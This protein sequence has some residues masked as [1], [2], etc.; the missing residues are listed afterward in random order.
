MKGCLTKAHTKHAEYGAVLQDPET[1]LIGLG[2]INANVDLLKQAQFAGSVSTVN[3]EEGITVKLDAIEG[4]EKG[5]KSETPNFHIPAS[6]DIW[7]I[8]PKGHYKNAEHHIDIENPD[9]FETWDV[10][11][12]KDDTEEGQQEWWEWHPQSQAPRFN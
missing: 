1:C 10:V 9:Y 5:K 7:F 6:L 2:Y 12:K 8:A 11:K 4:A 3:K